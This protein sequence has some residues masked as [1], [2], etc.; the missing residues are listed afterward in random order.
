MAGDPLYSRTC[1][2]A[3]RGPWA[4]GVGRAGWAVLGAEGS[5][6]GRA[7]GWVG[8]RVCQAGSALTVLLLLFQGRSR[9]RSQPPGQCP[10][11]PNLRAS[12]PALGS[13]VQGCAW[14]PAWR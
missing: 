11:P 2:L 1:L 13:S 5:P 10:R 14:A 12:L 6:P 4:V 7:V 9:S 8:G 3:A